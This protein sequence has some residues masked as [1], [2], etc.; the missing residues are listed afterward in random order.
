[1]ISEEAN[2]PASSTY[3]L[4]QDVHELWCEL[5][6]NISDEMAVIVPDA[7]ASDCWQASIRSYLSAFMEFFNTD[8]AARQLMLGPATSL[9]IRMAACH[10]DLRF[11]TL[12]YKS[13]NAAYH[14]P[15]INN[16]EQVF[17]WAISIADVFFTHA[18]I[19]NGRITPPVLEEAGLAAT[20]YLE[21]YIPT[22]V[23]RRPPMIG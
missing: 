9:D 17:L 10:D 6:R 14:L 8:A 19:E 11:G 2:I 3:N 16:P 1:M 20:A 21:K 18:V 5:G 12:L 23:K 4:F 15:E 7:S 13:L 22:I